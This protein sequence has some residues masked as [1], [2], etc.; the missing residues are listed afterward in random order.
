M[1]DF[2][3]KI[4]SGTTSPVWEDSKIRHRSSVPHRYYKVSAPTA[5]AL[6]TVVLHAIVDGVENPPDVDLDSRPILASR[7]SF[8]GSFPFAIVQAAGQSAEI[9]LSFA[10]SMLGHQELCLRRD[11]GGAIVISFDVES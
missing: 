2:D 6:A 3:V 11:S 10:A 8:S 7:V 9:T 1:P 5:P 4:V